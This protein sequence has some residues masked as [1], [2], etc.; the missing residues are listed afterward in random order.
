[1]AAKKRKNASK[2]VKPSKENNESNQAATKKKQDKA[3]QRQE[4]DQQIEKG[5]HFVPTPLL[6]T[7]LACSGFLAVL[8]YRDMFGTGKV[9]FGEPDAAM[10]QYTLST[11]WF[12]DSNGWKSSAG[13]F[14]AVHKIST[15][16]NDMG[17]F[18][19]RKMAGAAGLGYHLQKLMPVLFQKND[20]HW[21]KRHYVPVMAS[22]VIGNLCLAGYFLASMEDFKSTGADVMGFRVAVVLLVEALVMLVYLL[23]NLTKKVTLIPRA[24]PGGKRPRSIV[25]KI[26]ARTLCLVTGIM[27]LIAARDFFF[28]GMELPFPPADDIYLEWTGAFIHSPPP[29]SVEEEE[30]G[31]EAALHVGDKFVARLMALYI[32]I[33]SVQKFIS[34]FVVRVGVDNGGEKKSKMFWQSQAIFDG[35]ILFTIR[36]FASPALTASLDFRWHA[37]ALGYETFLLGIYGYM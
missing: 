7:I 13:G 25:S 15:D 35:L 2:A 29:N 34:G 20:V 24:L 37:M 18:F 21:G 6:L 23:L 26:L 36:V 8:S 33:V 14:S 16:A 27:T 1:M 12:D 10:L 31:L 32:L 19:I 4:L 28:P 3:I 30:H 17:G 11:Q 22:S 9:I 5:K